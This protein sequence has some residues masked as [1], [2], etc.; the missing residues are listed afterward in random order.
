MKRLQFPITC[1]S[2]AT[3]EVA[4]ALAGPQTL[5]GPALVLGCVKGRPR[6]HALAV[7]SCHALMVLVL[8]LCCQLHAVLLRL[9]RCCHALFHL[10]DRIMSAEAFCPPCLGHIATSPS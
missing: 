4:L 10:Q 2:P 3:I 9:L 5:Q 1:C 6:S 7:G 8:L